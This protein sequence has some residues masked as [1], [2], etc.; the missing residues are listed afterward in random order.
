MKSPVSAL[1]VLLVACGSG[2]GSGSGDSFPASL[3]AESPQA[4]KVSDQGSSGG[5]ESGGCG[6][7]HD[8][9]GGLWSAQLQVLSEIKAR[10][11]TQQV[12]ASDEE[13]W[14]QPAI[15]DEGERELHVRWR[16]LT[17]GLRAPLNEKVHDDEWVCKVDQG[18]GKTSSCDFKGAAG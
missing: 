3:E 2:S 16:Y 15:S 4:G 12:R 6:H 14:V 13:F 18:T 11:K 1:F 17:P 10:H 8:L 5:G 7:S 9:A